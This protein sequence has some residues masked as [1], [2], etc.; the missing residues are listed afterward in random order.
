MTFG[1]SCHRACNG[2]AALRVIRADGASRAG[3]AE[4]AKEEVVVSA[5]IRAPLQHQLNVSDALPAVDDVVV[6]AAREN[7]P[8]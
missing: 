3:A 5:W 7:L 4:R 6:T 1:P 2:L 8:V